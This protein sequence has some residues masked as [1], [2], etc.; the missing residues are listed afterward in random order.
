MKEVIHHNVDKIVTQG[1]HSNDG[2]PREFV[3]DQ[4]IDTLA[5]WNSDVSSKLD[6]AGGTMTGQLNTTDLK[7]G[8]NLEVTGDVTFL[9][10]V[11]TIQTETIELADN[12]LLLN[13][14]APADE[15]GGIEVYRGGG[16]VPNVGFKWDST[17]Q[18][19]TSGLQEI[20]AAGFSGNLAGNAT[21]ADT[22]SAARNLAVTGA[23]TGNVSL[24]GSADVTLTTSL[25]A[26]NHSIS[27][28]S[29]ISVLSPADGQV[30]T[31]DTSGV[32]PVWV[33]KNLPAGAGPPDL[34][35]LGQVN[36]PAPNDLEVL[37][38]NMTDGEWQA[39]PLPTLPS[40]GQLTNTN[41]DEV[42]GS[43]HNAFLA[44]NS[45]AAKWEAKMVTDVISLGTSISAMSDVDPAMTPAAGEVLT[46]VTDFDGSGNPG[47]KSVAL[48]AD[49]V[50]A[51][52]LSELN[53]VSSSLSPADN[54]VL[55]YMSG[56]WICQAPQAVPTDLKAL[57]DVQNTLAPSD[58]DYLV[59]RASGWTAEAFSVPSV[60]QLPDLSDV[61]SYDPNT[62]SGNEVLQFDSGLGVW[63]PMTPAAPSGSAATLD[64]LTGV[65]TVNKADDYVLTYDSTLNSGAGGWEPRA[66]LQGTTIN[67]LN[68]IGDVNI[69]STP[70]DGEALVFRSGVW[71]AEAQVD[72]VINK[73]EDVSDVTL[74]AGIA[75]GD[76][77]VYNA[78]AWESQ[79]P[80]A[81]NVGLLDDL[82]DVSAAAP[83]SGDFL[84]FD[85]TEWVVKSPPVVATLS[86]TVNVGPTVSGSDTEWDFSN[87]ASGSA[88]VTQSI[89]AN[90]DIQYEF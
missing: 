83:T 1:I 63:K 75:D 67:G 51:S 68:D 64:D 53:D 85:G 4:W 58:G 73:L 9:G 12:I 69:S 79:T 32:T 81:S 59:Y 49:A 62:L 57:T 47:W 46:Y 17:L 45:T 77:L 74:N 42:N 5:G 41:L 31:Y 78:G 52:Q 25:T 86:A 26:H 38:Y 6:L 54:H 44:Y 72:T 21:S 36:I 80:A 24:D 35:Q 11:T 10:S 55:T 84:E 43:T 18:K 37:Q 22:W 66:Q 7:V 88:T 70:G 89:L 20:Q 34:D 71:G 60:G 65:T 19:W 29:E 15:D 56:E 76:V 28:V 27:E 61:Q 8:G 30:L 40:L 90:G 14:N 82:T 13:S 39:A 48:P 2:A 16:G 33:N 87:T 50:G 23:V 3:I